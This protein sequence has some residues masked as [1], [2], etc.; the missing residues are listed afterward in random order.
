MRYAVLID[1]DDGNYGAVIPDAPGAYGGGATV[2]E[3]LM[4]AQEGLALWATSMREDGKA[5][6]RPRDFK[7]LHADQEVQEAIAA[8]AVLASVALVP[9]AGKV[10]RVNV[11]M[12]AGVLEFIDTEAKSLGLTRSGYI[13]RA[14]RAFATMR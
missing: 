13:E 11:S 2:E 8:G 7:T 6:P 5:V 10:T 12:D 3:A 14:A 1:G 9:V 4:S